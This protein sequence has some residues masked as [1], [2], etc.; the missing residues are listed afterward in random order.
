[1]RKKKK[2]GSNLIL[3]IILVL[4]LAVL[5][6]SAYNLYQIFSEYKKGTDEY[7]GLQSY[8]QEVTPAPAKEDAQGDAPVNPA[9]APKAPISVDFSQLQKVNPDI[10]GWIYVE[11]IP[12]ISYPVVKGTDNDFY[13][14]HTVEKQRNS[15]ASIFMDFQNRKDFSDSNTL[16]YGHNMKNQSMFGLLKNLRDQSVY[17][18]AP[19]FW[20]LTPE[21]DYQYEVFSAREVPEDDEVYTLFSEGGEALKEYLEKMQTASDVTGQ[22]TF[23]GQEKIV[24]LSTCT[25]NDTTRCIVQGVRRE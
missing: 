2:K 10:V 17:E 15:S 8:V 11:A 25:G 1:M 5:V 7:E 18:K 19:Y 23:T 24:T 21:A 4:S 14:H 9:E 3:N 6:F 22:M 16:V 13:L 20:I 12:K